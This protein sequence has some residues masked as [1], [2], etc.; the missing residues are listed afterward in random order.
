LYRISIC[1]FDPEA[2]RIVITAAW[3]KITSV[4]DVTNDPRLLFSE[5][6]VQQI[7][8]VKTPLSDYVAKYAESFIKAMQWQAPE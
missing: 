2:A 5:E 6:V 4:A 7:G 3:P 1:S 8:Q